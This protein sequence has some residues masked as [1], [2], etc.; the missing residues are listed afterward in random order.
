MIAFKRRCVLCIARS[1]YRFVPVHPEGLVLLGM[2]QQGK[3][4]MIVRM[5]L[6]LRARRA[7]GVARQFVQ[8]HFSRTE[9]KL[10]KSNSLDTKQGG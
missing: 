10:V 2:K 4:I 6:R 8:P 1:G 9:S 3:I 5:P 7:V